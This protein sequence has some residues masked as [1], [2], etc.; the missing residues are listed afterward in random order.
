MRVLTGLPFQKPVRYL[1]STPY[2]L[3]SCEIT[4]SSFTPDLNRFS[5]SSITSRDR[6]RHEVAAHRRNDAERAAVVAAFGDLQV[7]VVLRRELDARGAAPGRRTDRAASADACAPRPSLRR[8]ACGPV[9]ASTFGC[10]SRMRS[11]PL[12][13]FFAPRQPVT[14]TLPFSAA[15]R[16]WRR[17]FL[18]GVVDEAAGVDDDEVGAVVGRRTIS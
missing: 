6:A 10:T 11:S 7:R 15:P 17:A 3:V 5:A 16:R 9:T 13:L 14:M 8:V 12:A 2:A 4:S 1:T 18:H